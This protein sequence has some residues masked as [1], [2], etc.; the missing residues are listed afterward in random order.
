M[1]LPAAI[2]NAIAIT[3]GLVAALALAAVVAVRTDHI[4]CLRVLTGSMSPTVPAGSLV[5]G[6][7]VTPAGVRVG[8]IVMFVPPSPYR[9]PSGDPIAHRIVGVA[10]RRGARYL[11]TKGDANAVADPWLIDANHTTLYRV[12][13]HSADAG[14]VLGNAHKWGPASAAALLVIP[15][16]LAGIRRLSRSTTGRHRRTIAESL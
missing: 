2:R 11:T 5:V 7:R 3:V 16:W 10:S 6:T 9:A 4:R 13:W 14:A 1:H 15:A 12:Q 8:D